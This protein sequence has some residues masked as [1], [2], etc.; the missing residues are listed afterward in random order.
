MVKVVIA[1][2]L[3]LFPHVVLAQGDSLQNFRNELVLTIDND[4]FLFDDYYYT[5][6]QDI[7]YR[8]W[9]RPERALHKKFNKPGQT[10]SNVLVTY[11]YGNKIFTPKEIKY[12]TPR[13]MDR[14]YA[15]WNYGNFSVTRLKG[16]STV[17]QME[18]E[19]GLIGRISGMGQIQQW[20]HNETGFPTPRGWDYQIADEVV[21]NLNYQI[22]KSIRLAKGIDIVSQSGVYAGTGLNKLS[23]DVTLRLINGRTI[24]ESIFTNSRLGLENQPEEEVFIFVGYGLDYVI[25]NIFLEG[26]LF[27]GNPSPFT[28]KAEPW[29]VRS[30]IG[31]MYARNR[32]S[33]I[34]S[35]NST[36]REMAG[37][38]KHGYARFAFARRF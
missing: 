8:R 1:G 11:R 27:S 25:S 19:V 13:N 37:G 3:L 23:Q 21:L 33:F 10:P 6:G 32:G 9:V 14:P 20:W 31:I 7:V 38:E 36:S 17:S 4:I 35:V 30:E 22:Y 15:G 2:L 16:K 24:T 26:S 18:A 28:V 29:L 12:R 34:F 5:A